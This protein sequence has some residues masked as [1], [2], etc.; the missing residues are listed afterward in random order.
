MAFLKVAVLFMSEVRVFGPTN[1]FCYLPKG[2]NSSRGVVVNKGADTCKA[3]KTR[4]GT[5]KA[6]QAAYGNMIMSAA[7][8]ANG[9]VP[10]SSCNIHCCQHGILPLEPSLQTYYLATGF[11]R[12]I[13]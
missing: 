3:L 12:V 7:A 11:G 6:W 10:P 1:M 2:D 5:A 13:T 9:I 8:T 4:P